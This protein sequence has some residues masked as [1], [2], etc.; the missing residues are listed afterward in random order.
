MTI[1]ATLRSTLL[2]FCQICVTITNPNIVRILDFGIEDQTPFLMMDFAP[3]GTIR[4]RYPR[5]T[6]LPVPTAV[7]YT[8]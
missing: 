5:G 4:Q 6:L 3:H 1:S 8:R 2:S 7:S